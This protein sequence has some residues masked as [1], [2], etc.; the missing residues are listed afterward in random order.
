MAEIFD[1]LRNNW[2]LIMTIF[3]GAYS[4]IRL[5]MDSKYVKKSEGKQMASNEKRITALESRVA[6]LPDADEHH[7]LKILL[8]K[9]DGSH[10]ALAT[11]VRAM[12]RNVGL[13]IEKEVRS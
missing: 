9:V 4:I 8:T 7:E 10:K 1:F 6:S 3:A 12:S 11:E 13:L 5:S 2:G